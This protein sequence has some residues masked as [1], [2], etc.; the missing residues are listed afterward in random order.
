MVDNNDVR[1]EKGIPIPGYKHGASRANPAAVKYYERL[2]ELQAGESILIPEE[3]IPTGITG[4]LQY[5]RLKYGRKFTTRRMD[6][7]LRI[8]RME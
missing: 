5:H 4:T 2:K 8:W 6:G 7:G 3:E 1:I